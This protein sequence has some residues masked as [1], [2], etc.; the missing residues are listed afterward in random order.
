MLL[1]K[2]YRTLC[3]AVLFQLRYSVAIGL[4]QTDFGPLRQA[5]A[6]SLL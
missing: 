6:Q 3:N 4:V 2:R 5:N 1:L